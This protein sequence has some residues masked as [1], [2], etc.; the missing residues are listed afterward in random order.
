MRTIWAGMVALL[1]AG[2]AAREPHIPYASL[3]RDG[4]HR[5][6]ASAQTAP[7]VD[8]FLAALPPVDMECS[9]GKNFR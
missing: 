8:A 3:F 2:C 4:N 7:N 6:V 9:N 5:L 1:V